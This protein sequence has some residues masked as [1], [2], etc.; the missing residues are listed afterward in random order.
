MITYLEKNIYNTYLK[1]SRSRQN[2]PYRFRK[3]FTD[4]VD[5][6]KYVYIKRLGSFFNKFP[7]IDMDNFFEAPYDIFED[8]GSYDLKFYTTPKA[9]RMY[10]LY[11]KKINDMAPDSDIQIEFI[12]KSLMNLYTFCRDNNHTL[13]QYTQHKIN[14][15]HVC[16]MH[17]R[18]RKV[19]IYVLLCLPNF[20]QVIGS[21]PQS[22]LEFTL[23]KKF[24]N[25]LAH[26]KIR[27]YNCKRV[28]EVCKDGLS[29][30]KKLLI[31]LNDNI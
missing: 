31:K 27:L 13:D 4:F 29:K 19:S 7:H 6:D 1:V 10:G 8:Q 23:G 3:D 21:Y 5:T 16:I 28:R 22:R 17:L 12:K 26:S 2:L 20:D 30:I 9:V 25:E 15:I 18:E 11:I 14:D 24:A